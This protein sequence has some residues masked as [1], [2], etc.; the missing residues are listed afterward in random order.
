MEEATL[1]DRKGD[2]VS[3]AMKYSSAAV[4]FEEIAPNLEREEAREDLRFAAAICEAWEK[5]ELAEERG[6]AALYKIAAN[7]FGKASE[8]SRR[9]TAELTAMG[10]GCFC[11]ALEMGMKF[12]AT[13]N[14]DFYSA[15]K[16]RME[17]AA[18]YY[19]RSGFEKPTLWVEATKRLFDAYVYVGK[20]EA[21]AEPEK[22]VKFYL[23]AQKCL[24]LAAKFYGKAGYSGRK[25]EVL[26]NLERVR[27]E[28][29]LAF[30]LS[31]VLAA[32]AVLSSTTR[33]SMPDLTE[34]AAG[35][36]NFESANIR[37]IVSV[38]NEFVPGQEFEVNLDLAN[39]GKRPGLLVR[40]EDLVPPR[41]KVMRLPSYCTL[42]G[43]SL[44]MRGRRLDPLSVESVSIWVQVADIV[45]IVLSPLV[46]YV[47]ELGDFRTTKV[48]EVKI[49][50]V[51]EFE[52]KVAQ[53]V[54]N[55]LVDSFVEDRVK[56][57][58]SVA[59]SGWRSLP[60][61]IKGAGVSKRSLYGAG[62]RMGHG[63]S[64]LQR[65]GLVD[66]ETRLGERGRGGRI[67]R[68]GICREKESVKRYVKEKAP[69]LL[70]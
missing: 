54:F 43:T 69:N 12:M 29:E 47:D 21:E 24:E 62:G 35:L 1:S 49:L 45:S 37:A 20:A 3:S 13:S 67:L 28:R 61:V 50:P 40:I 41:C 38:P 39:V 4:I 64:E 16:S 65:K 51:V 22:R 18:G 33:V 25:N 46:V 23:M 55:Y 11:E 68:V 52:S 17:S 14:M 27:K 34:K 26:R 9:K 7:L 36:D 59:K 44:N 70:I 31:E 56:Q 60:Q 30:S 2:R 57:R 53:I 63:I 10:N 58:L 8:I 6:D 15:A 66:L 5:M 42:E 19:Q 48:E 32:P